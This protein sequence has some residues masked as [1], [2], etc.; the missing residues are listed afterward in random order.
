MFSRK[1]PLLTALLFFSGVVW[2][3]SDPTRPQDY[4]PQSA[5]AGE[6]NDLAEVEAADVEPSYTLQYVLVSDQRK[7]A[8]INGHRV[9]EGDRVGEARV[10]RIGP[11]LVRI[12]TPK[13]TQ[14]LKLGYSNIKRSQGRVA[15]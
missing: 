5:P 9:V 4:A 15:R 3:L 12:R 14:E 6:V 13:E 10:V 8:V 11:G 1:V 2:A 7:F